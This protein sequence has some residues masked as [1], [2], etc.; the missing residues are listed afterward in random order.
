MKPVSVIV[1][2]KN[3]ERNIRRC[4][5][6]L[7]KLDYPEYEII[8]VDSSNDRT[9]EMARSYR[10]VR[11]VRDMDATFASG[12]NRGIMESKYDIVAFTDA[13]C[14]I[15]SSLLTFSTVLEKSK[16]QEEQTG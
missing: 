7:S 2:T 12:R 5:D 13:D 8:V 4:L 14:I 1:L 15:P 3:E 16:I 6:S 9:P 11:V 10:N